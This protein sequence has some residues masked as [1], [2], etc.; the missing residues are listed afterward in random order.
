MLNIVAS[1]DT[2]NN[3]ANVDPVKGDKV[4][5]QENDGDPVGG[6]EFQV[7]ETNVAAQENGVTNE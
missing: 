3:I 6:G 7:Q 5:V 1:Y 4:L 2:L